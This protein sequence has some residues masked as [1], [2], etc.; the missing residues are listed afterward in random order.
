MT[1]LVWV[2]L[3]LVL[4]LCGCGAG[5]SLEHTSLDEGLAECLV[6]VLFEAR[7]ASIEP[8]REGCPTR[9]CWSATLDTQRVIQVDC[10]SDDDGTDRCGEHVSHPIV[11]QRTGG[12]CE[13]VEPSETPF[14][15]GL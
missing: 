4:A 9:A 14:H 13:V 11:M 1:N 6:E 3:P 8:M 10:W 2:A 15:R 7:V 12:G 5:A